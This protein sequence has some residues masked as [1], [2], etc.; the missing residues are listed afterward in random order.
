MY[1]CCVMYIVY[2]Y[3][4]CMMCMCVHVPHMQFIQLVADNPGVL[5]SVRYVSRHRSGASR[6]RHRLDVAA[7]QTCERRWHDECRHKAQETNVLH[8]YI[9]LCVF[10]VNNRCVTELRNAIPASIDGVS[11]L[12][13][14]MHA[15]SIK[16][17]PALVS[18]GARY[19]GRV[20]G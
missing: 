19:R 13:I 11:Q 10:Q 8:T 9:F 15:L 1:A 3:V 18:A 17:M 2:M 12:S 20:P 14:I 7:D 6:C 4:S 5:S 16:C